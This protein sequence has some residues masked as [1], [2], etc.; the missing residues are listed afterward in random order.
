MTEIPTMPSIPE[1]IQQAMQS[2]V[3]WGVAGFMVLGWVMWILRTVPQNIWNLFLFQLTAQLTVTNRDMAYDH[4]RDWMSGAQFFRRSRRLFVTSTFK[5]KPDEDG[6]EWTLYPGEGWF[7]FWHKGKFVVL[8]H[9]T[10]K[11]D[12][13]EII[14]TF[15]LRTLG[16]TQRPLRQL[17]Y[18]IQES[19]R[20]D[21]VVTVH[22]YPGH[23]MPATKRNKRPI[24]SVV[25]PESQKQAVVQ[26][27]EWFLHNREWF[28]ERGVPW[29]RG[30]LLYGPPG[31]GKT[32]LVLALASHLNREVF[33]LNLSQ[34]SGERFQ[35]AIHEMGRYG[36]LL[37]EDIDAASVTQ[38]RRPQKV[39][40]EGD[41]SEDSGDA[42]GLTMTTL[43]NSLDGL[44]SPEGIITVMTTN[45]PENLD[46][47]LI[48]PGRVDMQVHIDHP[49]PDEKR[50]MF[51][52][53]FPGHS[54]LA[55]RFAQECG[56]RSA[57]DI[58][59]LFIQHQAEPVRV[60]DAVRGSKAA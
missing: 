16:R 10:E 38:E 7:F 31:T 9:G 45:H 13:G 53:F 51:E 12:R 59:N 41:S 44:T 35:E 4:I 6:V 26:D 24:E 32:S 3:F 55:L 2:Q 54:E 50:A 28:A 14:C 29:R 11:T 42:L 52:R 33:T 58:Q 21:S 25:L 48:R 15:T 37:M 47:A 56:D 30:Y 19:A 60:L 57:A 8:H 46:Q 18:D 36:I 1:A 49:G 39:G 22:A 23:W 40:R 17:V 20:D 27:A 5:G 43:L 34:I